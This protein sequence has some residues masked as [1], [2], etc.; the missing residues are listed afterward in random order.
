VSSQTYY[1]LLAVPAD[2]DLDTIRAS[3]R[4]LSRNYHPDVA[5]DAGTAMMQRLNEA[6][7]TL[8]DTDRRH[9][10]NLSFTTDTT[11][12]EP[13]SYTAADTETADEAY[14][15]PA[16]FN[17]RRFWTITRGIAVAVMVVATVFFIVSIQGFTGDLE[18]HAPLRAFAIPSLL[19]FGL[20]TLATHG[21]TRWNFPFRGAFVLFCL[22]GLLGFTQL[23]PFQFIAP[24]F[25]WWESAATTVI[26]AA[27]LVQ[28]YASRVLAR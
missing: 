6:W 14:E 15:V 18:G 12:T 9:E 13:T 26:L 10:Y 7:D 28:K 3:Y 17:A 1:D 5:G 22:T 24:N 20:I 19:I 27:M 23:I 16:S 21:T 4:R 11:G 8:R 25:H 2:A